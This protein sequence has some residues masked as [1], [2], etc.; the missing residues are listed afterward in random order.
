MV[1]FTRH[2]KVADQRERRVTHAR[3][4]LQLTPVMH[5]THRVPTPALR[6]DIG[7]ERVLIYERFEAAVHSQMLVLSI[8]PSVHPATQSLPDTGTEYTSVKPLQKPPTVIPKPG[9]N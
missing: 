6:L 8:A 4:I 2:G 5:V 1:Y 7:D 3:A 9:L